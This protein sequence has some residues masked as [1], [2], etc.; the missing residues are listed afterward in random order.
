L[1]KSAST[2]DPVFKIEDNGI[3]VDVDFKPESSGTWIQ[4]QTG[5]LYGGQLSGLMGLLQ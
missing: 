4:Y 3:L 2:E 5:H 1:T